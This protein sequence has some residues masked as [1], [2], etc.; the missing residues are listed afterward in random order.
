MTMSKIMDPYD[1]DTGCFAPS[2]HFM[3]QIMVCHRKQALVWLIV[4]KL[5]DIL[6]GTSVL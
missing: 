4:Y 1:L 5:F 2:I 6:S 3:L